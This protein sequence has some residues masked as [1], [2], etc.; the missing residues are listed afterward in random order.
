MDTQTHT[1]K[2]TQTYTDTHTYV[3]TTDTDTLSPTH[4]VGTFLV[5]SLPSSVP[6]SLC[7]AQFVGLVRVVAGRTQLLLSTLAVSV[8][9]AQ[10]WLAK[11]HFPVTNGPVLS[12]VNRKGED[13]RR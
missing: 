1:E 7:P 9:L 10:N 12:L 5:L 4:S 6:W 8:E 11:I 13:T 2:Y 3:D